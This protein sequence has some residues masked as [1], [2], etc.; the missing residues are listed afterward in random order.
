MLCLYDFP[1]IKAIPIIIIKT[2]ENLLF[3]NN[4]KKT[5]SLSTVGPV[6]RPF[7]LVCVIITFVS[8]FSIQYVLTTQFFRESDNEIYNSGILYILYEMYFISM[9]KIVNVFNDGS[10]YYVLDF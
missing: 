4:S 1:I 10:L 7:S 9:E 8:L 6:E 2:I 3:N 5:T